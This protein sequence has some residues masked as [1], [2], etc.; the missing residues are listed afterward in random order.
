MIGMRLKQAKRGFF[1]ADAVLKRM[2]RATARALSKFGSFV[3]TRAR[4]SIKKRKGISAPGSP[5]SSH[6]GLLRK[7]ILFAAEPQRKNV[8]IGPIKLNQLAFD[9]T[10]AVSQGGVP[11]ILEKGGTQTVFEEF[12]GNDWRRIDARFLGNK[13]NILA[14]QQSGRDNLFQA[15]AR[16]QRPTRK[17]TAVI[18]PRPYMQPAFDEE[19]SRAPY[20]WENG[21]AA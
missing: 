2:D 11:L 5:P 6:T 15:N 9:V 4:T 12:V 20:L 17:R 21:I 3:R 8:V 7:W 19:L 1:D 13:A 14:L 10:G 16:R 18:E